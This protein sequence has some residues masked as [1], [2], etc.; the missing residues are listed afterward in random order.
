MNPTTPPILCITLALVSGIAF[1]GSKGQQAIR[2]LPEEITPLTQEQLNKSVPNFYSVDCRFQPQ[3]GKRYWLRVS[4]KKWIE[5][6]PDGSESAFKILG[7]GT[8]K[9]FP[10]TMF[11]ISSGEKIGT[12]TTPIILKL[13]DGAYLEG[14]LAAE[15]IDVDCNPDFGT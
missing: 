3:P 2:R 12:N 13:Q 5:R 15:G 6:Y 14:M 11:V 4:G 7:H 10:G 1:A 8:V 9:D